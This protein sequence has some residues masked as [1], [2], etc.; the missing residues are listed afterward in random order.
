MIIIH[1]LW[2]YVLQL[3]I[4][5]EVTEGAL[6]TYL[7]TDMQC[8]GKHLFTAWNKSNYISTLKVAESCFGFGHKPKTNGY[9]HTNFF[10]PPTVFRFSN[11]L[12]YSSW[13]WIFMNIILCR[14]YPFLLDS[15]IQIFWCQYEVLEA[16]DTFHTF[17]NAV[18]W[19]SSVVL[20]HAEVFVELLFDLNPRTQP[21]LEMEF[22]NLSHISL[23]FG[24]TIFLSKFWQH[25]MMTVP[26]SVLAEERS[27]S[28]LFQFAFL[29]H[30][31]M[32]IWHCI[33]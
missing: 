8:I 16:I 7:Q 14:L 4:V 1:C 6:L 9:A 10:R 11:W 29:F 26:V 21:F 2:F 20:K 5:R 24:S 31:H 27:C 32:C 25:L 30:F 19:I 13:H 3:L 28:F 17:P 12:S 33:F 22:L 18:S 23:I 15:I